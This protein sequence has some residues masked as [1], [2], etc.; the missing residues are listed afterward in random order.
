VTELIIEANKN[1]TLKESAEYLRCSYGCIYKMAR[2]GKLATYK[3]GNQWRVAG[4][5]LLDMTRVAQ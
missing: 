4:S 5:A 1:Y 2:A 3:V